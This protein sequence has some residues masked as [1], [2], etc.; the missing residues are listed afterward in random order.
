MKRYWSVIVEAAQLW[1][2]EDADRMAAVVSYYSIFA[3]APLILII[4]T[5]VGIIFS[6][7]FVAEFLVG[8]A[9]MLG[10]ELIDLLKKAVG[11][12]REISEG[13]SFP[14]IS[15]LFLSSM[16]VIGFNEFTQGLHKLWGIPY[17]GIRGFVRKSISSILFVAFL[18][19]YITFS[20]TINTSIGIFRDIFSNINILVDI[21]ISSLNFVV[22]VF[23]LT[24]LFSAAYRMLPKR[25]PNIK[26]V[27][28][29]GTV[30][31]VLFVITKILIALYISIT[32]VPTLY[33]AA[34]LLIALLI[35]IFASAS[36]LYLGAA[37]AYIHA[38]RKLEQ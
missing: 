36:I 6:E 2:E 4:V 9:A 15:M 1:Y 24:L 3:L 25:S 38:G 13:F 20:I 14:I 35:W 37:V 28:V 31:A 22:S 29:G 7:F 12:L 18:S 19:V 16:T 30:A 21:L 27:L 17:Q 33:G 34:G 8:W 23:L 10:P 26:S 11:N 5:L 32:P